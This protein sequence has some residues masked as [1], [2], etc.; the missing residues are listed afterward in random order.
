MMAVE[1]VRG[2]FEE[3][4]TKEKNTTH[5]YFSRY[6]KRRRSICLYKFLAILFLVF[7][8]LFEI[9]RV[10]ESNSKLSDFNIVQMRD[11]LM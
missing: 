2:Q 3:E 4:H 9:A 10:L 6:H 5:Y 8:L 11:C 7:D 1:A